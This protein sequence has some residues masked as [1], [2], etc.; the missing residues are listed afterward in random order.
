MK[1]CLLRVSVFALMLAVTLLTASPH[2]LA[3]LVGDEVEGCYNLLPSTPGA[4]AGEVCNSTA[5]QFD[6]TTAVVTDP[7]VEFVF[8]SSD[9]RATADLTGDTLTVRFV[10]LGSFVGIG[11]GRIWRFSGLDWVGMPEGSIES[12]TLYDPSNIVKEWSNDGHSI[13]L[14]TGPIFLADYQAVG[15]V[16]AIDAAHP[17]GAPPDTVL[18]CFYECKGGEPENKKGGPLWREITTLMLVNEG[19]SARSAN[20]MFLDGNENVLARARDLNLSPGDLDE[21]N[22]CASLYQQGIPV[23]SAGVVE[24][25]ILDGLPGS[26]HG[27]VK[28][29]LGTFAL[30]TV[31]PFA[32]NVGA[33]AKTECHLVPEEIVTPQDLQQKAVDSGAPMIVPILVEGTDP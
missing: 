15:A 16:F 21:I 28:N 31:E 17:P 7:G 23:P 22:V 2:A 20:M 19:L 9:H 12:V 6:P 1:M 4:G 24:I 27:W 18:S 13:S 26:V 3:S 14:L 30:T 11:G 8:E 5:N 33:I 29:L 25:Y 32:G 10:S